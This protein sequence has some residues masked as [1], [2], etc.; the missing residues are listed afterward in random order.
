MTGK[1]LKLFISGKI[2]PVTDRYISKLILEIVLL[3]ISI[4]PSLLR[5]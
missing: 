4:L 1:V 2:S 5:F 3:F